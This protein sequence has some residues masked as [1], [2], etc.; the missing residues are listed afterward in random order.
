MIIVENNYY[1]FFPHA[2]SILSL[3]KVEN[4]TKPNLDWSTVDSCPVDT[5][6]LKTSH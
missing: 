3:P 1:V 4:K 5:L 2:N 6:L